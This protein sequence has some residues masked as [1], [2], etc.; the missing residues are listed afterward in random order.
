MAG[1]LFCGLFL[2]PLSHNHSRDDGGGAC[3]GHGGNALAEGY[4]GRNDGDERNSVDVVACEHSAELLQDFI[5]DQVA[6]QRTENGER[7]EI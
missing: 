4:D 1:G 6:E 3:D 7:E 2:L 5:P